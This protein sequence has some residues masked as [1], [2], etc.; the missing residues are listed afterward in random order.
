M[1][2]LDVLHAPRG[3]RSVPFGRAATRTKESGR[4][5]LPPLSVFLGAGVVPRDSREDNHNQLGEDLGKYLVVRPG[6][7]VFNKLRTWQ[8]GLG[9]SE[10]EGIVSPAYFVCRPTPDYDSRFLQYLLLSD[11]YLQELTRVSKWQPP[12]QFDIGWEQLRA[13]PIVSP[14]VRAQRAI[15]DYLDTETVRIDALIAKKQRMIELL[16]LRWRAE[17]AHRMAWIANK[18]GTVQLRHL[19]RCLDG[20]RV[21]L[22]TEE[23]S[24]RTGEYPYYGASGI[25]DHVN[26]YIFDETLVLLGEDGAQLGVTDY[27]IAQVVAGKIW[28]NNHAHVLR[29][30][31]VDPVFLV[32]HLNTFDRVPFI[33]GGT[34]EKITQEDMNRIPVPNVDLSRQ[35]EEADRLSAIWARSDSASKLLAR[36]IE[37]LREHRQ[38][39]ITA[40]VTGE[41]EVP[42]VAA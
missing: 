20:S 36:Q 42:G 8:G 37:L 4:P 18:F 16:Q 11:A 27:P 40:A 34:R 6:D 35:R 17:T 14:D 26:S 30:V 39:L 1:S 7:L 19:V 13:V 23:R 32:L 21:P 41:L 38:A 29:P 31:E 22:S 15:A 2:V 28:V 24:G 3:W 10:H 25:V 9:A 33:S 12:S 5:D